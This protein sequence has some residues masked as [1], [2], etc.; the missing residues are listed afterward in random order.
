[1][2]RVA[3]SWTVKMVVASSQMIIILGLVTTFFG[4]VLGEHYREMIGEQSPWLI[5]LIAVA[6]VIYSIER[7]F[8]N[9]KMNR[10]AQVRDLISG[11]IET[12]L[13]DV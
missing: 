2:M 12:D 4:L 3:Q 13:A 1:M 5:G 10:F 9:E 6:S 8:R 7:Y 11:C